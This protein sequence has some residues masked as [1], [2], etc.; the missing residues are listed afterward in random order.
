VIQSQEDSPESTPLISLQTC[1]GAKHPRSHL[2]AAY[3]A[4][5]PAFEGRGELEWTTRP[6]LRY[7]ATTTGMLQAWRARRPGRPPTARQ[8]TRN[9]IL[10]PEVR[11]TVSCPHYVFTDRLMMKAHLVPETSPWTRPVVRHCSHSP[12]APLESHSNWS[13]AGDGGL[14]RG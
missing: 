9:K 13:G 8:M 7:H 6:D 5:E 14:E 3:S 2:V 10:H 4:S 11:A 1:E 12:T